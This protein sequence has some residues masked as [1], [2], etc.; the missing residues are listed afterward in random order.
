MKLNLALAQ[1]IN[2]A[3]CIVQGAHG[4][5]THVVALVRIPQSNPPTYRLYD[6]DSPARQAGTYTTV[7]ASYFTITAQNTYATTDLSSPLAAALTP[8]GEG[9]A[10]R[11][12]GQRIVGPLRC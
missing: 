12:G 3:F 4:R 10:A 2:S 5:M 8:G 7:P 1:H 11:G 9:G 6:N